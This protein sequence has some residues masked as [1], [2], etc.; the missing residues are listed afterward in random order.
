MKK[1]ITLVFIIIIIFCSCKNNPTRQ[2]CEKF[3]GVWFC[4]YVNE[5]GNRSLYEIRYNDEPP[6]LKVC[7]GFTD[8]IGRNCNGYKDDVRVKDNC[9]FMGDY[10]TINYG[11]SNGIET[12][13][14]KYNGNVTDVYIK[15]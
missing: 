11:L 4:D 2:Q 9:I 8:N 5:Y 3:I 6:Y 1:N 15:Q 14:K 12:L 13:T 10:V 7:Y